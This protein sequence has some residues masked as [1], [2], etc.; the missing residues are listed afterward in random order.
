MHS[1]YF[2]GMSWKHSEYAFVLHNDLDH[3]SGVSVL[4]FP[5]NS[6]TYSPSTEKSKALLASAGIRTV[7]LESGE[8]RHLLELSSTHIFRDNWNKKEI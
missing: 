2:Y 4:S 8:S 7:S 1:M 3:Q 6:D 5:D